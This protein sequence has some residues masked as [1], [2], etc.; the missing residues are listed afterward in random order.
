MVIMLI[1]IYLGGWL[2]VSFVAHAAGRR[3]TGGESPPDHPLL[4]SFVAGAVWPLLVVGLV[5]LSSIMVLTRVQPKT[6]PAI[7]ILV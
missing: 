2:A 3:L 6:A 5:E 7:G 4:L 1:A